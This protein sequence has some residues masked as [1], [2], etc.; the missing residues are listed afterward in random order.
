MSLLP[1]FLFEAKDKGIITDKGMKPIFYTGIL[2]IPNLT[3]IDQII[4]CQIL[5]HALCSNR[6]YGYTADDYNGIVPHD[7]KVPE[8]IATKVNV[9]RRQFYYSIE[10]LKN[11]GLL[12]ES[13][14]AALKEGM[15]KRYFELLPES[16]LSGVSLIV[17]S[18]ICHLCKKYGWT[19]RY[20][21]ALANDLHIENS[22]LRH[23]LSRLYK[24]GHLARRYRGRQVLL[25]PA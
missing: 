10:R 2:E 14:D 13:K 11:L 25:S 22:H 24:S 5:Y 21:A 23:I 15:T 20:H 3:A 19:D 6:E 12:T 4:Y 18:Y 16:G 1:L 8:S 7:Y 17:Y 9:S